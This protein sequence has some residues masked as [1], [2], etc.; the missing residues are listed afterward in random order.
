MTTAQTP[1]LRVTAALQGIGWRSQLSSRSGAG[2]RHPSPLAQLQAS[3]SGPYTCSTPQ[4][5]GSDGLRQSRGPSPAALCG[6]PTG[7]VGKRFLCPSH[8][9]GLWVTA[10]PQQWEAMPNWRGVLEALGS[11]PSP[12]HA[13]TG[14][15]A[16]HCSAA[17]SPRHPTLQ[18]LRSPL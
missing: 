4:A 11:A 2:S 13:S 18:Q 3:V 6:L 17:G 12:A 7:A 1:G 10:R 15:S 14:R 16:R 9:H 5:P 8:R